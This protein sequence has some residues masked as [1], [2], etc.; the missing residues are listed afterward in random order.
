MTTMP[1]GSWPSP[2]SV[3]DANVRSFPFGTVRIEGEF[4]YFAQS[5]DDG[6]SVIFRS[7]SHGVEHVT[8]D[9]DNG[10][11]VDVASR[12]HEYGGPDF[13]VAEGVLVFSA[14]RD[15]RLYMMTHDGARWSQPHAV[16]PDDGT[17]YADLTIH[18]HT[19]YGVAERHSDSGVEN[20]IVA[21]N[22]ISQAITSLRFGPDFVANPRPSPSGHALAWYEW[23]HPEM[24]W[25]ATRL[26]VAE[27]TETGLHEIRV[28]SDQGSAISPAWMSDDELAFVSDETGWW[29]V[30][31]LEDPLGA[32]R[33]RLIHPAEAEFASPP[34]V[35]DS[36]LAPLDSEYLIVRWTQSGSWSLGVMRLVNGELEEW[37]TGWE[38]TSPVA[39]GNGKVSFS[40]QRA[41]Q[42]P[43]IVELDLAHHT[44]KVLAQSDAAVIDEEMLSVAEALTWSVG[45]AHAY[46]FF[47]PP[48]HATVAGPDGEAPPLLVLVH[49]GPTA[50]ST[51]GYSPFVQFWTTRGFAVLDV[52]YRGSTGYG[53]AYRESLNG[54]WGVADIDDVA[55]GVEHLANLGLIDPARV[56][57]RGGS[58]GGYTVLRALTATRVFTAGVSR[59]GIG[60]LELL[61]SDTHKFEARYLDSLLGPY[62][63]AREI[64]VDRSPINHLD[65]LNTPV[66]LLQGEDDAVV[67]PEQAHEI[68]GA[69]R[70]HGGDVELVLYPGE[71]HG[72]RRVETRRD[73]LQREL[74]FYARVFGLRTTRSMSVSRD[75]DPS[76]ARRRCAQVKLPVK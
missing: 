64:Y 43:A 11:P 47:Y 54:Q 60:N 39:A 12:V 4:T 59:Y 46:G 24:P 66:L 23:D 15:D 27:L 34:W 57:I 28:I 9:F 52:N 17:R 14:R 72:W 1:Y 45:A 42:P 58:A 3:D 44:V 2:L 68:A 20:L 38:P 56:A 30:H 69:I 5:V 76:A 21:V 26:C 67:S 70:E 62:P 10:D 29:N 41:D 49:G 31:R 36:S 6:R 13:A 37:V 16:T 22:L 33:V 53:R 40:G 61:V 74:D 73:S 75:S 50:A 35:F 51:D 8:G 7:G 48:T 18:N 71:G 32:A 19:V 25:T 65:R 55:A 63:E